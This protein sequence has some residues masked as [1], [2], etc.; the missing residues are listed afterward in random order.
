MF[1]RTLP[2]S[3]SLSLAC[4]P[5]RSPLYS[6]TNQSMQA[7]T[8]SSFP[9]PDQSMQPATLSS[10]SCTRQ[11]HA[12]RHFPNMDQRGLSSLNH[13]NRHYKRSPMCSPHHI[14]AASPPHSTSKQW[15]PGGPT[16]LSSRSGLSSQSVVAGFRQSC[17]CAWIRT[18]TTAVGTSRAQIWMMT[19]W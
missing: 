16:Q 9:T 7:G 12:S 13:T 18:V 10:F 19:S 8:L 4:A 15:H 6:A 17:V 1:P 3:P 11:K 5:A 14:S 2:L